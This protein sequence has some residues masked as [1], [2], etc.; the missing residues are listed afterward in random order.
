M[1]ISNARAYENQE[2]ERVR[3]IPLTKIHGKP[4]QLTRM[5][6]HKECEEISATA[7]VSYNWAGD[8]GLLAEFTPTGQYLEDTELD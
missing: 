7:D 3:A 8:H 5:E 1:R 4:T 6:M 2:Y